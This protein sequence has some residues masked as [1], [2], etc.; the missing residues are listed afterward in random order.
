VSIHFDE[1]NLLAARVGEAN[2]LS[3]GE[4]NDATPAA[5]DALSSFRKSS[6][7]GRYGFR[8]F[9]CRRQPSALST[10]T[11]KDSAAA[12]ILFALSASAEAR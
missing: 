6:D 4:V 8:S 5:L 10:I 11:R 2:G 1:K 12:T 7:D 3:S 9:R